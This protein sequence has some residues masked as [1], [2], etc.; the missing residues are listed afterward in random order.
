M[1]KKDFL[2]YQSSDKRDLRLDFMRGLIMLYVVVVHFEFASLF[3]LFAWGRLGIVSSAEGFVLLSGLVL[4]LVNRNYTQNFGL[5]QSIKKLWLR[6]FKL[7]K[8]NLFVILTIP[9]L[10][11]LPLVNTFDVTHWWVP[12]L[13]SQAYYLYPSDSQ[14]LWVWL[15]QAIALKIGPH[16]FQI[17][18]LYVILL[19]L[20]PIAIIAIIKGHLRWLL[21]LSWT[22]YVVNLFFNFRVTS[23]RFEFGFPLLSWRPPSSNTLCSFHSSII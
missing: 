4:G 9:L 13:R 17:I 15:W 2:A 5:S 1:D 11:L 7:Y 10:G 12:A 20:A 6:A 19:G 8:V 14:S 21:L 3:S 22:L 16:Q 18:G 23:A